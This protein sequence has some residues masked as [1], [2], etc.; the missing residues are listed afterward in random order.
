MALYK[1]SKNSIP[2]G[3][4]ISAVNAG[5]AI[6]TYSKLVDENPLIINAERVEVVEV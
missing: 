5:E 1:I 3:E 2:T 4:I 6:F